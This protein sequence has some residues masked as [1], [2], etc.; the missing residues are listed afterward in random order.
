MHSS[1]SSKVSG[2]RIV[3]EPPGQHRLSGAWRACQQQVVA[4]RRG[5]FERSPRQQLAANV[6]KIAF[7]WLRGRCGG[8]RRFR[9]SRARRFVQRLNRL[10]QRPRDADVQALDDA[11]F[12][13]VLRRQK[14]PLQTEAAGADSD[15]QHAANA[16]DGAVERQLADDDGIVDRSARQRSRCGQQ[17]KGDRQIERRARLADIG[18]R[19]V[20]GDPVGREFES[21]IA[22]GRADTVAAL[23]DRRVGQSPPWRNGADRRR[24]PL[25]RGLDRRPL[26][27][28]R[29]CAGWQARR[30][31]SVQDCAPRGFIRVCSRVAL[32]SVERVE[33]LPRVTRPGR[34]VS[35]QTAVG[36]RSALRR[37]SPTS[38][39]ADVKGGAS[40]ASSWRG[41]TGAR[42]GGVVRPESHCC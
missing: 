18:G 17:A 37:A 23:A 30:Q 4:A 42:C 13:G 7:G 28:R 22:D 38:G 6:R 16:V 9:A 2:G 27:T 41:W 33:F 5:H 29:R 15:R 35:A 25:P 3:G 40:L 10:R 1:A 31:R 8:G 32:G 19:Q 36:A 21:R 20:D 34:A 14:Q 11:R 26:R 24:R 39:E 12:G